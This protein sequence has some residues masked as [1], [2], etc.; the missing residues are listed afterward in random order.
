[1]NHSFIKQPASIH[2]LPLGTGMVSSLQN[3]IEKYCGLALTPT[4]GTEPVTRSTSH[5]HISVP[6]G[7]VSQD[8]RGSAEDSRPQVSVV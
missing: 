3:A 7:D 5:L 1:V 2:G 8:Q 6:V 4:A